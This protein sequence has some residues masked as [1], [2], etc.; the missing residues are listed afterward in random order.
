MPRKQ[1]LLP[2]PVDAE[3]LL[4]SGQ[5]ISLIC[6]DTYSL[7]LIPGIS[8]RTAAEIQH[9]RYLILDASRDRPFE[10]S[11]KLAR[12]IGDKTASRIARYLSE[13][14]GCE[15]NERYAPF[16]PAMR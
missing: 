5:P 6:A 14:G 11:L 9:Q 3:S 1:A 15:A 16:S 8:D 2:Q 7:E 12:G 13:S 10:E 4:A